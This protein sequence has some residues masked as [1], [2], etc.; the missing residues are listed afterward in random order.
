MFD[1]LVNLLVGLSFGF[2][3]VPW[4]F[5]ARWGAR[6]VS[7]STGF[8]VGVLPSLFPIL[9][10]FGCGDCG[11]GAIAIFVLVPIWIAAALLTVASAAFAYFKF[12][13]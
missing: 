8:A 2:P 3:A 12:A 11:Q 5:V 6:G 7:L 1:V 10:G 9:F 4:L 13:R